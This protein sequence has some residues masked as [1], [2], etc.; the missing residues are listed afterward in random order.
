MQNALCPRCCLH[1][2]A[3]SL[4]LHPLWAPLCL[5]SLCS[6]HHPHGTKMSYLPGPGR[7]RVD[8][9]IFAFFFPKSCHS[10]ESTWQY[11]WLVGGAHLENCGP[12]KI[13][14]QGRVPLVY[15]DLWKHILGMIDGSGRLCIASALVGC[16][17][18]Q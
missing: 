8:D 11:L 18:E 6:G 7:S 12:M 10:F 17:V 13:M 15:M 16:S 1:G 2:S 14:K 5:P 4:C 9:G 3:A